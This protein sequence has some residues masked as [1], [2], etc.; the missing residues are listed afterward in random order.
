MR[1]TMKARHEVIGATAGQYR[2]AG[3]KEKGKILDQFISTTGYSRWYARLVLRH[4]G[5]RR[6]TDQK[7]ILLAVRGKSK[8]KRKRPR[9]Y[10]EKVQAAL[11]KL[12]RLMDYKIGRA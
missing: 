7:T 11:E 1:L 3:K 4:E 8:A 6:Q 9:L 12:W 10:D 2:G 5:R